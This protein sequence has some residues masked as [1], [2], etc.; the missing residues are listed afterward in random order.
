MDLKDLGVLA[1]LYLKGAYR[2]PF[3]NIDE[4]WDSD[5][6]NIWYVNVLEVKKNLYK[7][8]IDL[9]WNQDAVARKHCHNSREVGTKLRKE[10]KGKQ[11]QRLRLK[12][13]KERWHTKERTL[14]LYGM[15]I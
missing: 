15:H 10:R 8:T 6:L 7:I 14:K 11:R 9:E 12:L 5:P 3:E 4:D 1:E 2:S 13:R